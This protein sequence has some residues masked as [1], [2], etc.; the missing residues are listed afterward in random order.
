MKSFSIAWNLESSVE[1][2]ICVV[3]RVIVIAIIEIRKLSKFVLIPDLLI[4]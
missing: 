2:G 1:C 4:C 3:V